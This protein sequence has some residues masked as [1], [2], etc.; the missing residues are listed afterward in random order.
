MAEYQPNCEAPTVAFVLR[1]VFVFILLCRHAAVSHAEAFV[2][3]V[4][5]NCYFVSVSIP[6]PLERV[7]VW[8]GSGGT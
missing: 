8:F 1:Q 2:S 3:F 4:L 6:P 7:N 5:G